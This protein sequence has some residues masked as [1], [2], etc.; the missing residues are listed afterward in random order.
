V[1]ICCIYTKAN[2]K[3]VFKASLYSSYQNTKFSLG[4]NLCYTG[5]SV[6]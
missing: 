4:E 6:R 1:I 3:V 2:G 5:D